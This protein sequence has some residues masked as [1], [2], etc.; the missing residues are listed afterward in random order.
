MGEDGFDSKGGI[1]SG[2]K[3]SDGFI[4]MNGLKDLRRILRFLS[5]KAPHFSLKWRKT[6]K[7]QCQNG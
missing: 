3:F 1:E 4:F 2:D 5:G 7:K 6:A